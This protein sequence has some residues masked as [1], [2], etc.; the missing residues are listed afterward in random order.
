MILREFENR[1]SKKILLKMNIMTY[2]TACTADLF[3]VLT[4]SLKLRLKTYFRE[5]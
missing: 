1:Y 4:K 2:E 5:K 3:Y